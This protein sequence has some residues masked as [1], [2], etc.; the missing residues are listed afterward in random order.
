MESQENTPPQVNPKGLII[1]W[2][3]VGLLVILTVAAGAFMGK[4]WAAQDSR[5][6]HE[7]IVTMQEQSNQT[8]IKI[9]DPFRIQKEV[10]E[11]GYSAEKV[12]ARIKVYASEQSRN[13][14]L[15]IFPSQV[16]E[17]PEALYV[18]KRDLFPEIAE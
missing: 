12:S 2:F 4:L 15:T 6:A 13:G 16:F 8:T 1:G 18:N 17:A 14:V 9:I 7:Q 11:H 10:F 5:W 3:E